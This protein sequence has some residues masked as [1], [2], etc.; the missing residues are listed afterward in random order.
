MY[1]ITYLCIHVEWVS[2]GFMAQST[3]K[4]HVKPVNLPI[5][6]FTW[7]GLVLYVIN[8][9]LCTFS[10]QKI[11][12]IYY[13]KTEGRGIYYRLGNIINKNIQ[14]SVAAYVIMY[15]FSSVKIG[16]LFKNVITNMEIKTHHHKVL[17]RMII[18]LDKWGI[19]YVFFFF[20]FF[21]G[22]KQKLLQIIGVVKEYHFGD[23][24]SVSFLQFS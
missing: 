4:G 1:A 18:A 9:Y 5:H 23:D 22:F 12:M 21:F 3:H 8:Q 19:F 15:S 11:Y 20:F 13:G 24:N 2:R 17:F 16:I 10:H 14:L 7:V 6:T